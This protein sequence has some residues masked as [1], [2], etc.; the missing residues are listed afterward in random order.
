M[1]VVEA[2]QLHQPMRRAWTIAVLLALIALAAQGASP[3]LAKRGFFGVHY[4]AG[5]VGKKNLNLMD[6]GNVGTVRKVLYWNSIEVRKGTYAWAA[7]DALVGN[8]AARGISMLPVVYGSPRFVTKQPNVPPVASAHKR[9]LFRKFLTQAVKRYGKGGTYWTAPKLYRKQHPGKR[10]RPI[11]NWQIW[12]EP[13]LAKFFAPHPSVHKYATL[14]KSARRAI[15]GVDHKGNVILAGMSGRGHPSDKKFL[16]RFYRERRIKRSFDA[17]AVNPYAPSVKQVGA[18]IKRIRGVMRRHGDK[19]TALWISEL[20][21]GSHPPDRFGL[22][23]GVQ[24]QKQILT[25]AFRMIVKHR[26]AWHVKR[27]IW[28]DFRDPPPTG[29][30]CSF[31][32][33]AGLIQ[34]SGKTKPSWRAFKRFTH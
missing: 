34:H 11:E 24:G 33:S 17:V 10:P 32:T 8:L 14:V 28:F 27:L 20:G 16:N 15:H 1:E 23:K 25:K 7:T 19:R 5:K 21:W 31:C 26:R 30:G 18:K 9:K 4:G 13:N 6:K 12:N 22:N 2:G 29:G 3:A